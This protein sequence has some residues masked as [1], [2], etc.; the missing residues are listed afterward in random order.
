[1]WKK[2]Y[3]K[4]A[5][6]HPEVLFVF[7]AGNRNGALDGRNYYPGGIPPPT[8][9]RSATSTPTRPATAPRTGST[10]A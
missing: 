6:D 9:S 5:K 1:M 2:F 4:M 8:S 3:T 10:R 7:A